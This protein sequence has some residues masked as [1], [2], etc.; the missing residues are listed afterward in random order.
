MARPIL[1]GDRFTS[2]ALA[3]AGALSPRNVAL[4][5]DHDLAPSAVDGGGGR[6]GRQSVLAKRAMATDTRAPS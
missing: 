2:R 6:G 1:P 5:I 3:I 4:L